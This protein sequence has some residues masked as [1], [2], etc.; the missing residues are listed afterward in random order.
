M[1]RRL[2]LLALFAVSG[3]FAQ[4]QLTSVT[5]GVCDG[6]CG[7]IRMGTVQVGSQ[8]QATL[9][10]T[11]SGADSVRLTVLKVDND[12]FSLQVNT[13]IPITMLPSVTLEFR[14]TF[15]PKASGG[16]STTLTI[17]S[18]PYTVIGT[19]TGGSTQ[20]TQPSTP[21]TEPSTPSS[22]NV[23]MPGFHIAGPAALSSGQQAALSLKFD[24]V[25]PAN[26]NGLLVMDFTALGRAGDPAIC[27]ISPEGL[28]VKSVPF[29]ISAGED[30]AR[31]GGQTSIQLQTGTTAG[32][33]M[34]TATLG[35]ETETA[36]YQLA[37]DAVYIDSTRTSSVDGA[38]RISITGYDNTRSVSQVSF[39]F[40]DRSGRALGGAIRADVTQVFQQFFQNPELG[41]QFVLRADF[42]I[43]G[44][45]TQIGSVD[46]DLTNSAG[47]AHGSAKMAE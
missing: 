8:K 7:V 39:T 14:L 45:I 22:P 13:P 34:F 4:L 31:F 17:N 46:I 10:L 6:A 26:G 30:T 37:A 24:A 12:S 2:S 43:T 21:I 19:G 23:S 9:L 40:R 27:L 33:L 47:L 29:A 5:S 41:G 35:A 3:A 42:P 11:N 1:I 16:A 20:T 32:T 38:L 15:A 28:C 44:D 18:T 36:S 25:A